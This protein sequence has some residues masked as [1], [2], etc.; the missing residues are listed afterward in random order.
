MTRYMYIEK[1]LS[2]YSGSYEMI[3]FL[4]A[5]EMQTNHPELKWINREDD[6]AMTG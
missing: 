6:G 4:F 3:N 1:A 5:K 2:E